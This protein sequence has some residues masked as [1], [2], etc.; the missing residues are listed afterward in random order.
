MAEQLKLNLWFLYI[1]LTANQL[2][3]IVDQ[4]SVNV[5]FVSKWGSDL[6]VALSHRLTVGLTMFCCAGFLYKSRIED[7]VSSLKVKV[8]AFGYCCQGLCVGSVI[9]NKPQS[10][11]RWLLLPII[12]SNGG[13]LDFTFT[14]WFGC[15]SWIFSF[16]NLHRICKSSLVNSNKV[17]GGWPE[18]KDVL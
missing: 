17:L 18:T 14:A 8:H 15:A 5:P 16:H 2:K 12:F 6:G 4:S 13:M 9:L 11:V 7:K 10:N 1:C 3:I